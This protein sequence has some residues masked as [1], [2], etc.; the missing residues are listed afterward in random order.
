V[1]YFQREAEANWIMTHQPEIWK[2][3]HKFL[4]L[5]G[6]LTH[7]LTGKFID[8]VGCQVGYLPFD[9]KRQDWARASDWKW[10]GIPVKPEMLPELS[11][12]G[13]LLGHV[14]SQAAR[15]TGIPEGLPVIAA[16]ADKACEVIGAGTLEPS[17]GCISYGTTAT[18]NV[19]HPKYLEPIRLIP[20]YPSAVPGRYCL[21]VQIFRGYWMVSWFRSEFGREEAEKA[22]NLGVDAE[23]LFDRLIED[24]QPGG[25]GLILQPYWSPGIIQPGPEAKGAVIGFG[26]I[27]TRA[28]LYR[29][30]LEGLAY[31]LREGS[32]RI[33]KRTRTPIRA[34]RVSGGGS[35]SRQAMQVTADIFNIPASRPHLYETSGL[36]AA[37][38]AAAGL[39]LMPDF[40]AAVRAM[41]RTG[42][43]FEPDPRSHKLYDALYQRVY[44]RLYSRVKPLYREIRR[45][46]GYPR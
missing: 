22:K 45:I 23:A 4:L 30:I 20:A 5:S 25:M 46:T 42:D 40:A 12:P 16:A 27:H 34:L 18:I 1:A 8:S 19:T 7:R 41:T 17:T 31:A 9:Y 26:D 24:T 2:K 15:M 36:G 32:E 6:F 11:P 39:G 33:Q 14:T 3:T 37:I 13:A 44:K 35:Q 43:V 28:H 29:A 38:T 21:E 10:Q